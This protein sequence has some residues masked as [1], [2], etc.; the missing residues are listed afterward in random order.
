[1][2]WTV[3]QG[4][5]MLQLQTGREFIISFNDQHVLTL[6]LH[7]FMVKNGFHEKSVHA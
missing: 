5:M 7:S 6:P 2:L 3:H 1:M 4:H